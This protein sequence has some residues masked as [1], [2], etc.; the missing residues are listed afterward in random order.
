MNR[1][2]RAIFTVIFVIVVLGG[3]LLINS[4]R[5]N[6]ELDKNSSYLIIGKENLIAVYQDKLAVRIPYG[7][8]IDKD[9][10]FKDLVDNKNEEEI[11]KTVN[12]LLPVPLNNYMRVKFGQV[13]LNVKNAKN[14][15]ETT[16]DNKRYIVTSSLHSMYETLYNEQKNKNELNENIIVDVL[17]AN[18]INGY[19]RRTGENIKNKLGMKYNAANYEKNLEESYIILNDISNEKAEEIVMQLN[20]KYF[21]IQQVPTIPTL[22]NVVVILGQEKNIDFTIE[23]LGENSTTI[24]NVSDELKREGYKKVEIEKDKVKADNAFVEY[25]SEDYFIAYKIAK[26]LNISNFIENNNL[27]NKIRVITK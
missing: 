3:F 13:Q 25:A 21:K 18:G 5:K 24:Q 4:M 26:K 1:R 11:L 15:P 12:K 16:V 19:A 6:P 9:K 23:V 27:K 10:T 7:I 20:E 2:V 17:N 8:N 22:A 14:I